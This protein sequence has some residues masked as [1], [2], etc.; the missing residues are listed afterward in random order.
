MLDRGRGRRAS[1]RGEDAPKVMGHIEP[2]RAQFAIL[3]S[4]DSTY[5]APFAG[6]SRLSWFEPRFAI[7]VMGSAGSVE[8]VGTGAA[9]DAGGDEWSWREAAGSAGGSG[10]SANV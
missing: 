7:W 8:L 5:S 6:V 3:S 2:C 4:V 1:G 10:Y 9:D